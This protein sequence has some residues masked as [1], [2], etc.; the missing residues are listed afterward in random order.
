YNVPVLVVRVPGL[1]P[2]TIRCHR[3]WR[4]SAPKEEKE[5]EFRVSD[6]D[7]RALV[8]EFGLA[9]NLKN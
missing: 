6:A 5:P 8:E 2:L 9:A 7:S 4:G 1:Q 3:Q